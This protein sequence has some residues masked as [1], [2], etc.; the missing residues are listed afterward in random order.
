MYRISPVVFISGPFVVC[1][2]LFYGPY[3]ACRSSFFI[4]VNTIF[5]AHCYGTL[6][7]HVAEY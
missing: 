1:F 7:L 4:T 2:P 6:W 5:M 3:V